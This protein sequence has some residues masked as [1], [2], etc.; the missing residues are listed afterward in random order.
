MPY[1]LL[2]LI[3]PSLVTSPELDTVME[4]NAALPSAFVATMPGMPVTS[5]LILWH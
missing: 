3:V 5:L 1:P 4:L 2:T